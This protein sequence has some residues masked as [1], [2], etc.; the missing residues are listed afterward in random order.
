MWEHRR[1]VPEGS[2]PATPEDD[3][4]ELLIAA[5]TLEL[6]GPGEQN[7]LGRALCTQ[8]L[9]Y[10][11]DRFPERRIV[12]PLPPLR[13]VTSIKYVDGDGV[14]Q[15]MD[16]ADYVAFN[17]A[18]SPPE[19]VQ[20]PGYVEP[21]FDSC[22]PATRAVPEA[23]RVRFEAGYGAPSDVPSLIKIW[24][25]MRLGTLYENREQVIVGASVAETPFI[26]AMLDSLRVWGV[27]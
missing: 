10:R 20:G 19:I 18:G 21:S 1:L 27:R 7:W 9:E 11:I 14:L 4:L 8:T 25:L 23:V 26:N 3:L 6:D 16:P 12:L 24:L 13:S 2:P 22:W 17:A 15:T 5:A